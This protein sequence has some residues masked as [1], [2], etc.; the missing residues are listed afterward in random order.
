MT[1]NQIT[2]IEEAVKR[3]SCLSSPIV[4]DAMAKLLSEKLKHQTMDA[5]IK[6]IDKSFRVCGPAY[7]VRCYPGATF[8]MEQAITKAPRDYVIVCDGQGSDAGVMMGELMSIVAR[9]RGVAGAIIDGAVRDVDD[10]VKLDFPV[11][12]RYITPRS[13]TSDKLGQLEQIISC[14]GVVVRPGDIVLGDINGI[15]VVPNELAL[16]VARAAEKLQ[17]WEDKIKELLLQGKTLEQAV[18]LYQFPV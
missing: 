9:K 10:I 16:K 15:V 8:A 5:G 13:G 12:T 11:F 18:S 7:T 17:S 3:L 2:E 1:N 6:P 14:G 4:S